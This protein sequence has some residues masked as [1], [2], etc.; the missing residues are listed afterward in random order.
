MITLELANAHVRV[1][2][3]P[4]LV[5]FGHFAGWAAPTA[6]CSHFWCDKTTLPSLRLQQLR[7]AN[8]LSR[9]HPPE[10]FGFFD[11]ALL[12]AAVYNPVTKRWRSWVLPSQLNLR[13]GRARGSQNSFS[14]AQ[15]GSLF[16]HV[17]RFEFSFL[18]HLGCWCQSRRFATL[19]LLCN[20]P[21]ALRCTYP[22]Q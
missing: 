10:G 8:Q 2:A 17:L 6:W 14:R 19:R 11:S 3:R 22:S 13:H 1:S 21:Y 9:C 15:L 4:H 16:R 20:A 18:D 7:I 12:S 5:G